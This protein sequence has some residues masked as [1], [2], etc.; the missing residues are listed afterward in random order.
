MIS[1]LERFFT[2]LVSNDK[3]KNT[4][5]FI[6]YLSFIIQ[7]TYLQLP[8]IL[9]ILFNILQT[10]ILII[11]SSVY[12]PIHMVPMLDKI[13]EHPED[14]LKCVGKELKKILK[15]IVIFFVFLELSSYLVN[16]IL[17]GEPTNQTKIVSEFYKAPIIN[18]IL[19]IIIGPIT[20]EI[21]FR[22]LPYRFINNKIL[23]VIISSV[24]FATLHVINYPNP[25]YYIWYYLPCA[26][27]FGYRYYKTKDLLVTIS[28]H[29]FNN[30]IS[31]LPLILSLF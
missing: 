16:T 19:V 9:Q 3:S 8:L 26:F 6:F 15:E 28:I 5:A 25:F 27:Y 17:V 4:L 22:Y 30:L 11:F 10:L 31:M 24:I 7:L 18:L 13:Y 21:V 23:Y 29:I 14:F 20:E 12:I 2:D 1:K